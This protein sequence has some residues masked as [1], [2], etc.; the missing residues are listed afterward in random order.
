MSRRCTAEHLIAR[1][2]GGRNRRE[3]IAAACWLCN[4]RR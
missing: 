2:E 1:H 4:Q 3:N